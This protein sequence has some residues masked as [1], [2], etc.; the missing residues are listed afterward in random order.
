MSSTRTLGF[1][2]R[3]TAVA[4]LTIGSGAAACLGGQYAC[5]EDG[6]CSNG[7]ACEATG[8]CS[9]SDNH[10]TS[11]RRYG[12]HAGA[13]A[14]ACVP[15]GSA[16]EQDSDGGSGVDVAAE[17]SSGT[18]T[19][20]AGTDGGAEPNATSGPATATATTGATAESTYST[21]TSSP[22]T[23]GDT[24]ATAT[25]GHTCT[26]DIEVCDGIDNDGDGD[27]DE[28]SAANTECNGCKLGTHAD[29]N[30]QRAYW[31]CSEPVDW[32][33]AISACE[34]LG[35][36]LTIVS[37]P[38]ENSFL[39][40]LSA[41][42]E[43]ANFWLGASDLAVEE[44]FEWDGNGAVFWDQGPITG[45]FHGF[46]P[47]EPDDGNGQRCVELRQEDA[48]IEW[49]DEFCDIQQGYICETSHAVTCADE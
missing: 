27:I 31:V 9:F 15:A 48:L 34:G 2:G 30:G 23:S 1:A 46:G 42:D 25:A 35:G 3:F 36:F 47:A 8:F 39:I 44:V 33:G 21:S 18:G 37:S 24:A 4:G 45:E 32:F 7:G 29:S 22:T 10:C 40:E 41:V 17:D 14:G 20:G 16:G 38:Q 49:N 5:S 13:L 11:R 6:D 12:K 26:V 43:V 28:F 19:P